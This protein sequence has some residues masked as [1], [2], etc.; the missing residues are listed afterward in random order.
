[1]LSFNKF[2]WT[3]IICLIL[4]TGFLINSISNYL[5][6]R[7]NVRRTIIES[8]LPL[9][10]DNVYS[11]IQRDLLRPV[12]ISSLMASDTFLR[13]WVIAGEKDESAITRFL[14]ELKVEYSTVTSFFV[15]ENTRKYYQSYG[16]LK[17]I[18]EDDPRDEWFFRVRDMEAPFEINVDPDLANRDEMTIFINYRV[19]DY[20]GNFIGATGIGLTVYRVNH[21][22]SNYEAKFDRQIYFVDE[23][24]KMVLRPSN[25]PMLEYSSLH[26][27]DG[28][29]DVASSLLEGNRV[30]VTYQRD[31]ETRIL[32][33]R[34]VPE[35]NWFLIVEQSED[36]MLSPY[37]R[38]LFK[39][40]ATAL[41]ITLIVAW[42]CVGMI[43]RNQARLETQNC[44]LIRINHQNEA[45]KKALS[46]AASDLKKANSTLAQL[47]KEKDEYISIVA[48]DLRTPLNG[49]LG[50]CS[51]VE[52][53]DP[54]FDLKTFVDDVEDCG[55]RM[56]HLTRA[57]LDASQIEA[58]GSGCKLET[59]GLNPLLEQA[60]NQMEAHALSKKIT[61]SHDLH[62][63]RGL[64][65]SSNAHWLTICINN[66]CGNAV[67]YTPPYGRV[68]LRSQQNPNDPN[69]LDI[70]IQDNGPGISQEDQAK[71]FGKFVRLSARPT[72]NE[73][74]TGLGLYIVKKT[75]DRL[76]IK[77][78]VTSELGEGTTFTL[79]IP[80]TP[81]QKPN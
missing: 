1:M 23:A 2:R 47:N 8:S 6:S 43:R 65:V 56:L 51:L 72:A 28:L 31:G 12:F 25:S 59:L 21:L 48:H 27:L 45:Q 10:S 41:L 68:S 70:H 40:I 15:S 35:L 76:G 22:I 77:I 4:L 55:E 33:A 7:D 73:P 29:A 71:L 38:Q 74:S 63:T 60:V 19:L 32:N 54:N 79:S 64:N 50:H 44:Q 81:D 42:I 46:Q 67:N 9:T 49:I 75:C 17:T 57:L 80:K 36:S 52:L 3:W 66:L 53:E 20:G 78:H 13:D 37:R 26:E 58:E 61:L 24:G 62:A 69:C 34:Y 14:H 5:I 18:S 16:L 39:N 30:N 11:E